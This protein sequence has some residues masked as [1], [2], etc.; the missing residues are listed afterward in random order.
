MDRIEQL[1]RFIDAQPDD[2]FPRYALALE[3]KVRGDAA[4]AAAELQA[5]LA[6]K[7]DYLAAYLQLG[8]LLQQLEREGEAR[9]V[10]RKGQDCARAQGNQ[11]TLSELTTALESLGPGAG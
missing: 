8:M 11:H 5:L 9:D 7:P 1:R 6:R 2:P 10:L 3:R 4:G